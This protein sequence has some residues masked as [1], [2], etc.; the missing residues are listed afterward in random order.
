MGKAFSIYWTIH[1]LVEKTVLKIGVP[2]K[3]ITPF[4]NAQ[5]R[6]SYW[7]IEKKEKYVFIVAI[8]P[9]VLHK[10][11]ASYHLAVSVSSRFFLLRNLYAKLVLISDDS[12]L[13][14]ISFSRERR[15]LI[16]LCQNFVGSWHCWG[17]HKM[18][19]PHRH[20]LHKR[21]DYE[22]FRKCMFSF[23]IYILVFALFSFQVSDCIV[24]VLR[25]SLCNC[26]GSV[27]SK[28]W[29]TFFSLTSRLLFSIFQSVRTFVRDN[30]VCGHFLSFRVIKMLSFSLLT[31][32]N[33][34]VLA[35]VEILIRRTVRHLL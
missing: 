28:S 2:Q 14:K 25:V 24:V 10:N 30:F 20:G 34:P 6:F 21:I 7:K 1:F 13:S 19:A 8:S 32:S 9:V 11:R 15:I 3:P 5:E 31:N 12:Q 33:V 26:L 35:A 4:G 16:S 23:P 27:S 17:L 18:S 29:C 22:S